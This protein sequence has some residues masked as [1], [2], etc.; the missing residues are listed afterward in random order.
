MV[1]FKKEARRLVME[2]LSKVTNYNFVLLRGSQN[3]VTHLSLINIKSTINGLVPIVFIKKPA[4]VKKGR[5]L[6]YF[7]SPCLSRV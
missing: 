3:H 1:W 5:A 6:N 2:S 7:I 4:P